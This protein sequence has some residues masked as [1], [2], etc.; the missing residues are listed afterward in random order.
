MSAYISPTSST[1]IGHKGWNLL[2]QSIASNAFHN[3]AERHGAPSRVCAEHEA[4]QK[5]I[6]GIINL[7]EDTPST[8]VVW[9]NGPSATSN[10]AQSIA[11]SCESPITFFFRESKDDIHPHYSAFIA[12][13]AYQLCLLVPEAR[14]LVVAAIERDPAI[15]S[16]S[17]SDQLREL[18]LGPLTTLQRSHRLN[19]SHSAVIIV[20]CIHYCPAEQHRVITHALLDIV[21]HLP[22][23]AIL[24]LFSAPSQDIESS[25]DAGESPKDVTIITVPEIPSAPVKC[26]AR[27]FAISRVV[28]AI[29]QAASA[30]M[31]YIDIRMPARLWNCCLSLIFS[32]ARSLY[33]TQ[34]K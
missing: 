13:I 26:S 8:R 24:I 19:L 12:T 22:R 33:H 10:I 4:T 17:L 9:V 31:R 25:L 2:A 28:S 32:I 34:R 18:I 5:Q 14:T 6:T 3:S 11:D 30:F 16:R 27:W 21:E 1:L 20:D 7:K 29:R 23:P 15:L